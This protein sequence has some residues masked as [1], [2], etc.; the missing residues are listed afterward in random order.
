MED[1]L[2]NLLCTLAELGGELLLDC[3]GEVVIHLFGA[4]KRTA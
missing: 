2:L 3:G 1:F 4:L